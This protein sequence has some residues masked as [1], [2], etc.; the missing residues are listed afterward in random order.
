MF[1]AWPT[2]Y[3]SLSVSLYLL[4]S[5]L[6]SSP[7]AGTW[8]EFDDYRVSEVEPSS[9]VS[10]AAYVL[11]Y[12]KRKSLSYELFGSDASFDSSGSASS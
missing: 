12:R 10:K 8:L 4:P 7:W 5:L 3:D 1:D 2:M 9:V 6:F 11:F